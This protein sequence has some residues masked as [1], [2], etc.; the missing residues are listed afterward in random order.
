MTMFWKGAAMLS[1]ALTG[2]GVTAAPAQAQYYGDNGYRG[3]HRRWDD[4]RGDH[5]RWDD[6]RSWRGDRH[7]ARGRPHYRAAWRGGGQRC[8]S[9]WRYN[10]YRDRNVRV[11]ICR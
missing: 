8:W 9:E 5:R 2:L 10:P 1:L 11:R 7:Y 3:D 4:R 6:R